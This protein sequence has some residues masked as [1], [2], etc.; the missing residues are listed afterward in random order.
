MKYKN[1]TEEIIK[2]RANDINGKK[3]EFI[4]KPYEEM[5][6][7]REV[8]FPGIELVKTKKKKIKESEL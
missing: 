1:V 8:K 2:I 7:D 5:E 3:V 4:L 6:S